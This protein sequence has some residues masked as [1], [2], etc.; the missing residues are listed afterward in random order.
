M[1]DQIAPQ[2]VINRNRNLG[3]FTKE[4]CWNQF[5]FKKNQL[6]RLFPL[7]HVPAVI[8]SEGSD[9]LG[10]V[11][12]EY[13][14]L[15]MFH[16]LAFPERLVDDEK[17]WGRDYSTLSCVFTITLDYYFDLYEHKVCDNILW[18]SPRFDLYRQLIQ[19][20]ILPQFQKFRRESIRK[21]YSKNSFFKDNY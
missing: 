1:W 21:Y 3:S 17:E 4:E 10:V 19:T 12:G 13:A 6:V 14:T 2:N 7:F 15:Y 16:R 5:R 20:K 8:R 18:Y 9:H 11:D